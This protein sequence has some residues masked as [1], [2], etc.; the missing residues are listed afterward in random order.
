M[1]NMKKIFGLVLALVMVFSVATCALSA[2]ATFF[3]TPKVDSGFT[4]GSA[5]KELPAKAWN[6]IT[7]KKDQAPVVD[8]TD[9]LPQLP[10]IKD[11]VNS[12]TPAADAAS[13]IVDAIKNREPLFNL[14]FDIEGTLH[15]DFGFSFGKKPTQEAPSEEPTVAEEPTTE[16]PAPVEEPV[17]ISEETPLVSVADTTPLADV[18]QIAN[19]GDAGV[20]A[21][22][23]VSAISAAAFV[24]AK[25]K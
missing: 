1:A 25:K 11:V 6:L 9:K 18:E 21:I 15:T 16:A 12:E 24:V 13:P 14:Y 20:A 4:F 23:A 19:T 10:S 3:S 8:L 5:L 17:E 2:S 7:G 22:V